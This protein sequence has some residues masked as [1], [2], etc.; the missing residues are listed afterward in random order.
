MKDKINDRMKEQ[1]E[2]R[3]RLF[4]PRRTYCLLRI[5][6]K[7]FHAYCRG[8]TK[9][10]DMELVEHMAE[11][12][13]YLCE[14]IQGAKLGY[15]QSDEISILITDFDDISTNAWFDYNLQKMSSISASLATAKFNQLR[16][17]KLAVF[18]SRVFQIHDRIEV[19]N[20]FIARQKDATRNSISSVAQSL[21]S[22]KELHG[23]SSN[24]LQELIFQ[25]GQNW[26]DY[27]VSVKR[28]QTIVREVYDKNGATRSRWTGVETPI[29]TQERKFLNS[30]I[31]IREQFSTPDL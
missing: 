12:T 4:L 30:I 8:L 26:N 11:T 7:S 9:P 22:H 3:Y 27:P 19:E 5:D 10:F 14:N 2:N 25:K 6:G 18:D 31:P 29:F 24:E 13:K 1:Y 17:G 28:G 23:K 16:H 15:H 21:Y 20:Y